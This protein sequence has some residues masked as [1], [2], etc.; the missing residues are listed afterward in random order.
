M[1]QRRGKGGRLITTCSNILHEEWDDNSQESLRLTKYMNLP[2]PV[3]DRFLL[4]EGNVDKRKNS[5]SVCVMCKNRFQ[6]EVNVYKQPETGAGNSNIGNATSSMASIHDDPEPETME[7][8]SHA[9]T[10][11]TKEA[12]HAEDTAAVTGKPAQRLKCIYV[13]ESCRHCNLN[14]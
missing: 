10:M 12:D 5:Q 8:E 9:E 1:A 7:V 4:V 2:K 6:N 11:D 14:E 13:I 3:K